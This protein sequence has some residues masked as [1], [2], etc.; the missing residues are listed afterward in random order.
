MNSREKATWEILDVNA[1][2]LGKSPETLN[3]TSNRV[4]IADPHGL[5]LSSPSLPSI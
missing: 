1:D 2:L 3:S 4:K 5:V